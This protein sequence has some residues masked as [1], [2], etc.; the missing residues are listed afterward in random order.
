M[1]VVK[2]DPK[3]CL[4]QFTFTLKCF[5]HVCSNDRLISY[6]FKININDALSYESSATVSI[7]LV[8]LEI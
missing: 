8:L 6:D 5:M 2:D 7:L 3:K 1:N 4:K